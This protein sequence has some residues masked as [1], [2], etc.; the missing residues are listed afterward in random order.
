L[1]VNQSIWIHAATVNEVT[2]VKPLVRKLLETYNKHSFIMTVSTKGASNLAKE[3]SSKLIVQYMPLNVFHIMKRAFT[4]F[5]PSLI[6]L[7]ESDISATLL[8]RAKRNNVPVILINARLTPKLFKKYKRYRLFFKKEFSNIVAI[9]TQSNIDKEKFI[10]LKFKNVVHAGNL[11]FS[12]ELQNYDTH[13]IRKVL[14]YNFNDYIVTFG[15]TKQGE[16]KLIKE[17]YY[18]LLE[19][20]PQLKIV[21]VPSQLQ[22]LSEIVEL[23]SEEEY[24]FY[25]QASKNKPFLIIDEINLLPQMY[26]LSDVAL[27]GSS[28]YDNGGSN[29]LEAVWYEKPVVIG[30]YHQSYLGAIETLLSERSIIISNVNDLTLDLTTLYQNIEHRL[31]MGKK[32][33]QILLENKQALTNHFDTIKKY[34]K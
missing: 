24:S 16:E 15:S 21:I 32:A 27:V 19:Y 30:K 1:P 25:S 5:N 4:A 20:I 29:P 3:I 10:L 33:K 26:A 11:K 34:I 31:N 18:K 2:T 28:F 13:V 9:S 12:I 8:N 17:V 6:I 14:N 7:V 22:R 23:F